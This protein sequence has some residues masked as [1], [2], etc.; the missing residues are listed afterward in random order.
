A[1]KPDGLGVVDPAR[2]LEFLHAL[3]VELMWGVGPVT[4]ARLAEVGGLTLGPLA[5]TPGGSLEQL[6]GPAAGEKLAALAWNR[7][8]REIKT[9]HQA[10]SAGAQGAL[11]TTPGRQ[12]VVHHTR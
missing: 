2:E 9:H 3:P 5:S 7:D 6:L 11:A 8:A 10:R 12:R 1:A 4:K